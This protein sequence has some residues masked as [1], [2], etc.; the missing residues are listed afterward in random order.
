MQNKSFSQLEE[1]SAVSVY[2]H[3]FFPLGIE[4]IIP[5]LSVIIE[6]ISVYL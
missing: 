3:I 5:F 1:L 6:S 2:L 4:E